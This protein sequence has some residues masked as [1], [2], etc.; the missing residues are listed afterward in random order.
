M[1]NCVGIITQDDISA[2]LPALDS[3]GG[4]L[5]VPKGLSMV[6]TSAFSCCANNPNPIPPGKI[7]QISITP[8]LSQTHQQQHSHLFG[9]EKQQQ[10]SRLTDLWA[11]DVKL[12]ELWKTSIETHCQQEKLQRGY[13]RPMGDLESWHG[14][15]GSQWRACSG[16]LSD[17]M[18]SRV[19]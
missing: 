16:Q 17:L 18:V 3:G 19:I 1:A 10:Q 15:T 7:S 8:S 4:I 6:S 14:E 5:R 9:V 13:L 11:N 2:H 12:S